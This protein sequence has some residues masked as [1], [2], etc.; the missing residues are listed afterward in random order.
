MVVYVVS[1]APV[2]PDRVRARRFDPDHPEPYLDGTSPDD[3]IRSL[4]SSRSG[5]LRELVHRP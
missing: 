1:L 2:L 4:L 5:E 3:G